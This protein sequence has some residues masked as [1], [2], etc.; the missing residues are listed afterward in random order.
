MTVEVQPPRAER[1]G[2]GMQFKIEKN[3]RKKAE[4]KEI[5]RAQKKISL[6]FF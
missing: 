6:F 4:R 2:Y 3:E 5:F 1:S